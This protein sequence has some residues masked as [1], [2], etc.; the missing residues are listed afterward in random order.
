VIAWYKKY[1][2]V[3]TCDDDDDDDKYFDE[4]DYIPTGHENSDDE[5]DS[6]MAIAAYYH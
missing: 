4:F 2:G 5:M 3:D 6:E 1:N